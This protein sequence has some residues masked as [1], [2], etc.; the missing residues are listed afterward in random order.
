MLIPKVSAAGTDL[1]LNLFLAGSMIMVR[2]IIVW[3]LWQKWTA[4]RFS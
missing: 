3:Y 1:S 2:T 4:E